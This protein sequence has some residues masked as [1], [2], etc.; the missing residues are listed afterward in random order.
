VIVLLGNAAVYSLVGHRWHKDLG[1]ITKWRGWTIPDQD[2]QTWIC[3]TFH[4]SFVE[5]SEATDVSIIWEEDLEQAIACA[6]IDYPL[7][8][9]PEIEIIT[10]LAP[11]NDITS[12]E[13]AFDYETTG[14]K[15]HASGHRIVC[16]SV[17]DTKNHA[18]VFM[19]PNTKSEREPFIKLLTNPAVGKIAQNMKYEHAWSMVRL[20]TEVKNWVWDTMLA[21]HILDNRP[22]VTGLKFQTYVQFGVVDY[23]SEVAPFLQ[24]SEQNNGNAINNIQKLLDRPRGK[25]T[26]MEY[27]GLDAVYEYRLAT[28]QRSI[29][30]DLPF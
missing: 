25:R 8:V 28:R 27:C 6:I 14:L 3:P 23:A 2:F 10:D 24:S 21:S 15:P 5:R 19:M 4:P 9:T 18:Y 16:V 30:D 1:G 22:G 20:R 26:L 29:I 13:V 7:Y 17:A 12:G 11:L